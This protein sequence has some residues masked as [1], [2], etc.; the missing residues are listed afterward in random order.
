[1]DDEKYPKKNPVAQV[2]CRTDQLFNFG[3]GENIRQRTYFGGFDDIH[4]LPVAFKDMF[5]EK[6]QTITV[7]FDGTLGMGLYQ[8]GKILFPLFQGQLA[9]KVF[10]DPALRAR[11]HQLFF[12][13]C[14]GA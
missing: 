4:P 3:D 8:V 7:N 10:P 2:V 5:P 13:F 9:I 11:R 6:L 14:P 12:D 1:M